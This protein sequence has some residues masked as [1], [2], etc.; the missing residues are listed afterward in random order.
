MHK[1]KTETL[2][3]PASAKSQSELKGITSGT[4]E[5]V[6]KGN[7]K[8]QEVIRV[9]AYKKWEAAG[10]PKGDGVNFWLEAER[11]LLPTM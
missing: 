1:H 8:S 9:W 3:Q 7:A 4:N 6:Q 11:E 5:Q 2:A 10:K